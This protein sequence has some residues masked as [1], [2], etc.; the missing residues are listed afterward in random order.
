MTT[1]AD[2]H[3]ALTV[4]EPDALAAILGA[5]GLPTDARDAKALA[6]Q[7]VDA[8]WWSYSTPLGY[9]A[10]QASFEDIV[11][12]VAR[13]LRVDDRVDAQAPVYDQASQLTEAL[14]GSLPR[15]GVA[16]SDL[17]GESRRRL[18]ASWLPATL[19]GGGAGGS[20]AAR[21]G[22]AK[23]L[24]LLDSPIGRWLPYLPTI[25]PA[26]NT[27]RSVSAAVHAVSGPL[28]VAL[29]ILSFNQALGANYRRLVPLVLGVGALGVT[30]VREAEILDFPPGT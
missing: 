29:A 8:I 30:P 1:R 14:L 6:Q 7:I 15:S 3:A 16:L 27:A 2:V 21:W 11:H 19:L 10:D 17:D 28:G 12:H 25:G 13:R 9:F 23:V 4:H 24:G 5:S 22:A 20:F 26:V 18:G